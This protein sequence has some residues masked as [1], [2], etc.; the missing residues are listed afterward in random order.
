MLEQVLKEN[1]VFNKPSQ[2][3]NMDETGLPLDPKPPKVVHKRGERNPTSIASGDRSHITVVACVCATGYT[4]PP[5]VIFDR[6]RLNPDMTHSE[7]PG[8]LYGLSSKGWMGIELFGAWFQNHFLK[9]APLE[10]P[11]ILLMDGCSSHFC[12]ETIKLAS[13]Q[14]VILF[15]LPPNTTHLTQPLDKGCFGPLKSY[16]KSLCHQYLVGNPGQV[17]TC[18]SFTP[19]FAEAWMNAMTIRTILSG[20]RVTG[21]PNASLM[22]VT[23]LFIHNYSLYHSSHA[24]LNKC[25]K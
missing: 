13:S 14:M 19:I 22:M 21:I 17:M 12:P 18:Y 15:A 7:V 5:M 16:W 8:T 2:I 6:K 25:N 4:I 9:Y 11:I 3:F 23:I 20:F 1:G 10:R 24:Y